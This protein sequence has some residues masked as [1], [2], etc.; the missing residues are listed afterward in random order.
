M[1]VNVNNVMGSRNEAQ[2]LGENVH[3]R[4]MNKWLKYDHKGITAKDK[5]NNNECNE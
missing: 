1:T 4:N 3:T 2:I 5:Y